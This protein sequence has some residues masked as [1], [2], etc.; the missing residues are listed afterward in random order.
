MQ[1]Y[2]T[3][4]DQELCGLLEQGDEKAY[5]ELYTRYWPLLFRHSYKML[6]EQDQA[7]D[8]VQDIFTSLWFNREVI[9]LKTS[10]SA[11]L[12]TATR[13]RTLNVINKSKLQVTYMES[14]QDYI[15]KGAYVT[16]ESVRYN[17]LSAEIEAE[18]AKLPPRMREIFELRRDAGLSYKQIAV[19]LGVSDETVKTQVSRALKI[20]RTKFGTLFTLPFI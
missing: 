6:A 9:D 15:D 12:Y 5:A 7:M 3:L 13:N 18:I 8:V 14:L 16:D 19:K 11:Y 1:I 4:T 10:I 2:T 20:L 17:E